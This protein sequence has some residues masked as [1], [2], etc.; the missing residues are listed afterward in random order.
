MTTIGLEALGTNYA[1]IVI[2]APK[3]IKITFSKGNR[4]VGQI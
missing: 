2:S 3:E 4:D 1:R